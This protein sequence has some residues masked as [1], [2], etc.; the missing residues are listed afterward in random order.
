MAERIAILGGL[1]WA[2]HNTVRD[3]IRVLP[4]G[5]VVLLDDDPFQVQTAAIRQCRCSGLV[6]V[7]H[8]LPNTTGKK[9]I[10]ARALRDSVMLGSASRVLVFGELSPDR[11]LTLRNYVAVLP[12]ERIP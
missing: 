5:T 12:V 4:E 3:R 6:A 1:L 11:E 2:D 10:E 7:V 9:A 8:R